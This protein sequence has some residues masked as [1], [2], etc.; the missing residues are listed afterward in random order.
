MSSMRRPELLAPAGDAEALAAALGAGAD[1]VYFGLEEGLNARARATNFA[2]AE[3]PA[4]CDRIHRAG[5]RAFLTLNTLVYEAELPLLERVL[6]GAALAGVDA[7]IV[8]DP[9]VALLARALAPTLH[10]HASTQMTISSAE[11]ARFAASLGVVRV[12]APRELNLAELR[13]F[14]AG[15]DLELEVF[16]H[17]ALCMSWSGQCLTS[18][19]WGGRSANRGQCAQS[20]RLPYTLVVDGEPV[21]TADV[22]YLLS[23]LD[24]AAFRALPALVAMGVASLKIEGRMKGADYV[25]T[26]VQAYRRW[27]DTIEAK[28][29]A[30]PA[31]GAALRADVARMELAYSRG[32]GDGF[33]AG[34]DHQSLVEG[35]FPKHRGHLL[36]VVAEVRPPEVRVV[37]ASREGS[38]ALAIGGGAAAGPVLHPL[39]AVGGAEAG[40][41]RG[42]PAARFAPVAGMGIG[43]DTGR[44]E[45]EEPGGAVWAVSAAGEGWWLRFGRDNAAVRSV[46][47]GDRVWVTR[48]SRLVAEADRL[49][50]AGEPGGRLPVRITVSGAGGAPLSVRFVCR[51]VEVEE[52][53]GELAAARGEGLTAAQLAE[54]LGAFGGTPFHLEELDAAGLGEGLHLAPALLKAARRTLAARL[55]EGVLAAPRHAVAP[56]PVA[57]R[58]VAEAVA[59]TAARPF[60]PAP[61]PELVPLCR[62]DAQLDAVIAAGIPEVE[63]DWMEMVGLGRAVERARAAGLRVGIATVRV[64]KPGEEAFD[65]RIAALRPDSVLVRHWAGLVHFAGLPEGE[66]PIVHGDFSLNVTNSVTAHHILARGA[67]TLTA[68]HDLDETQLH[69]LLANFPAER[70]V[71]VLHHHIST[72]HTEHCVYAHTLSTGRDFRTCG[73]PCE[74]KKVALRDPLGLEHPVVVDVGCRNTVF[75]ARAQSAAR[76][77]ARLQKAGVRRFRVEFVW[78][79]QAQAAA[80]LGAYTELL[81]GRIS[82]AE[83]VR[84]AGAHE[85]FG[86]TA[87]TMRTLRPEANP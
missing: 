72:F 75:E 57:P 16:V 68:A 19:A 54:K 66:R 7:V 3:L 32:L 83:A 36:G 35:R 73:R 67:D 9:A 33:F 48:D 38:G 71:V 52:A 76:A 18:E 53:V 80:V 86:V 21:D 10:V 24:Q 87:G 70:A 15:T 17:G 12:V 81:A 43:F 82:A 46:K 37:P 79:T 34:S 60:Q 29:E 31:S 56:E 2:L 51:G 25:M 28:R 49:V 20:C 41:A 40:S 59:L 5:A 11:A 85:Q 14:V 42:V 26:A 47:P 64:H 55:L 45:A 8:Q 65:R 39:P 4:T 84:R 74:S 61:A 13:A 30:E 78:E 62:N 22:R 69:A 77:Y 6:R 27:L 63:L 58:V 44:P 23:P 50:Q 1:A